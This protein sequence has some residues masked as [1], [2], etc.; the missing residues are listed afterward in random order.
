MDKKDQK[1]PL[2][3]WIDVSENYNAQPL[4]TTKSI[5]GKV[6]WKDIQ[7]DPNTNKLTYKIDPNNWDTIKR[8]YQH[9]KRFREW[10]IPDPPQTK[11]K[12][13]KTNKVPPPNTKTKNNTTDP[14]PLRKSKR[15]NPAATPKNSTLTGND[16]QKGYLYAADNDFPP[17]KLGTASWLPTQIGG[18]IIPQRGLFAKK[19]YKK[20]EWITPYSGHKIHID[21]E[22]SKNIDTSYHVGLNLKTNRVIIGLTQPRNGYGMGQFCN[23]KGKNNNN[24]KIQKYGTNHIEEI[25]IQATRNIAEGE[26]ITVTYCKSHFDK[27]KE[28]ESSKLTQKQNS[29][30]LANPPTKRSKQCHLTTPTNTTTNTKQLST[31]KKTIEN[32]MNHT[33]QNTYEALETHI[34]TTIKNATKAPNQTGSTISHIHKLNTILENH[35][36][37]NNTINTNLLMAKENHTWLT[38]NQADLRQG[39]K[40]QD[41]KDFLMNQNTLINLANKA[42]NTTQLHTAIQAIQ[43]S[44]KRARTILITEEID[45]NTLQQIKTTLHPNTR[46]HTLITCPPNSITLKQITNKNTPN[47]PYPTINSRKRNT[48]NIQI[49]LI[50]N[51]MS[52][53]FNITNLRTDITNTGKDRDHTYPPDPPSVQI[54]HPPWLNRENQTNHNTTPTST[55]ITPTHKLGT[56]LA[57]TDTPPH[58][59]SNNTPQNPIEKAEKHN[60]LLWLLGIPPKQYAHC[61]TAMTNTPTEKLKEKMAAIYNQTWKKYTMK[62]FTRREELHKNRTTHHLTRGYIG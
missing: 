44:H 6:I 20:N 19:K 16:N 22:Q 36:H 1:N 46:L 51:K 5:L 49:I 24:A 33:T 17:I 23:D 15:K 48:T 50:E 25:A 52:P 54:H 4:T 38:Q 43:D 60:P 59:H 10:E 8:A 55:Q 61:I 45:L 11:P 37:I 21:K 62:A 18:E 53:P 40:I 3:G 32:K 9:E 31:N 14:R 29:D 26:E 27:L 34:S 41:T 35:F 7:T 47:S 42:T 2:G 57:L 30:P 13:A 56:L 58:L 12:H 39:G 28:R